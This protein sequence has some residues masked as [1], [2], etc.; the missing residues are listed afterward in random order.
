ML[1]LSRKQGESIIIGDGDKKVTM[2][3]ISRKGSEITLGFEAPKDIPIHREEIYDK[4]KEEQEN[5][6]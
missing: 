2:T 6:D 5:I 4:I 3:I 1:L